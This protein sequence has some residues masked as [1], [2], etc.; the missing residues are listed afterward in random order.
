MS[1]LHGDRI[2]LNYIIS[3]S[4]AFNKTKDTFGTIDIVVNNAGIIDE[5][6]WDRMVD[7]NVVQITWVYF[8]LLHRRAYVNANQCHPFGSIRTE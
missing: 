6:H 5:D 2:A 8:V 3:I 7:I 1:Q 4:E